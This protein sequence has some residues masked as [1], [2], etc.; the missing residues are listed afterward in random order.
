YTNDYATLTVVEPLSIVSAPTNETVP[1][2]A[3]VAFSVIA[4]GFPLSYQWQLNGTNLIN[5]DN[6]GGAK[7]GTLTI[8]NAQPS[9][10]GTY[11]VSVNNILQTNDLSA[12][13]TVTLNPY[14]FTGV[15]RVTTD[16][17]N[18]LV[19]TGGGGT[20]NGAYYVLTSTNLMAPL[21]QWTPIA[22][23]QFDSQGQFSFTNPIATNAARFF[24]LKQ[25]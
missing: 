6:I 7:S 4:T 10:A 3:N 19:L 16:S 13:L 20:T 17:G 21:D 9:N 11:I 25:P 8:T 23:N 1:A 5:G 18:E 15:T 14:S 24:I 12:V 22:T 2:G